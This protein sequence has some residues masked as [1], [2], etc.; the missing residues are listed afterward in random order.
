M[1][2]YSNSMQNTSHSHILLRQSTF[3]LS[4]VDTGTLHIVMDI[5][6]DTGFNALTI[7][8]AKYHLLHP[9]SITK[10]HW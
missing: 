6:P 5:A 1:N 3:W 2:D 4:A 7:S 8:V 10:C 9:G